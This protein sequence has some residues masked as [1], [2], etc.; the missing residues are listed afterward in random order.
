MLLLDGDT[1]AV[2]ARVTGASGATWVSL[3]R[4]M[5]GALQ[6]LVDV[7]PQDYYPP[8]RPL[9]PAHVDAFRAQADELWSAWQEQMAEGTIVATPN[10]QLR[11]TL[12]LQELEGVGVELLRLHQSTATVLDNLNSSLYGFLGLSCCHPAP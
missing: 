10:A 2:L 3:K 7:F 5:L 1:R 4:H 12:L 6:E 11:A 8:P 9:D